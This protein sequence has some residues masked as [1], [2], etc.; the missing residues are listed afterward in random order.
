MQLQEKDSLF[1][2][3]GSDS[4]IKINVDFEGQNLTKDVDEAYEDVIR[5]PKRLQQTVNFLF[6]FYFFLKMFF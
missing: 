4:M 3:M 1:I 2:P 5:L 6:F